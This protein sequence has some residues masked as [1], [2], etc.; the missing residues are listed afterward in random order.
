MEKF[1]WA[2]CLNEEQFTKLY[3]VICKIPGLL[4]YLTDHNDR[5]LPSLILNFKMFVETEGTSTPGIRTNL[6]LIKNKY[7]L[8]RKEYEDKNREQNEFSY[9]FDLYH[10]LTWNPKPKWTNNMTVEEIDY[11]DH[12][13]PKVLGL[14]EYLHKNTNS[15]NLYDLIVAYQLQLNATGLNNAEIDFLL[16]TIKERFYRIMDDHKEAIHYVNHSHQINDHR[17]LDDFTTEA[18]NSFYPMEV[19]DERCSDFANKYLKVFHPYIASE[20]FQ[21]FFR[22]NKLNVALS[23]AHQ[24]FNHIFS[25]PNIYWHNKEAIFGYVN[26]LHNILDALGHKGLNLLHEK[27]PKL[28][29]NFLETLYLLLSRMIYWTDKETHKDEKYDDASLPI[30]VQHKLRAYKLRGFLMEH[31][32]ELLA[33][34]IDNADANKMS[35]A[36][37]TAAHSMA[38]IHRIVGRNSIFKREADRVFHLKG[39]FQHCTPEKAS[40]DGFRMSDELAM[41][42]HKKYKEGKYS[43]PQKEVSELILFLRTYF[44][45]EQKIA[46]ENNEPISYL[47]KDNFS[48][49]YKSN[50]EEIRQYLQANGIQYLYHFTEKEK[51]QSIIKYGGLFSYKRAFDESIAMPVR[52]D[53]ALTRDIDARM[54]LEDYV[55]TSF[56]PR[57]P[58]IKERQAEGAELV[59]LKIDLDVALFDETLYT[60]MEATQSNMKHGGDFEDLKKVNLKATQKDISRPEDDDYWQRQAEVLIKGFIPLKYILNVKSPEILV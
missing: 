1:L 11:L 24:E 32:G 15:E 21:K 45:N 39:I 8:F 56:C 57:L 48:P 53:M 30:N 46:L 13:I 6:E 31:Y 25:S 40:E 17:L 60:D 49:A 58:K 52:E 5:E 10:V 18:A 7:D 16:E 47:Q 36:D 26:I 55:R 41:A 19:Q 43:L 23:F 28:Q 50:K 54:G 27:S 12:F 34:N 59:L 37:Y 38:Y 3:R 4:Q 35:F 42:I 2:Y 29:G 51:I 14:P 9:D 20:I 22:A 44:K 33:S